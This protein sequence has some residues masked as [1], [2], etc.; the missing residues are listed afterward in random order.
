MAPEGEGRGGPE[1]SKDDFDG[2]DL[3]VGRPEGR[4]WADR[5]PPE[6]KERCPR[7]HPPNPMRTTM[8]SAKSSKGLSPYIRFLHIW[9]AGSLGTLRATH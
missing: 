8:P 3:L 4:R 7:L 9:G 6:Q 1:S 5:L 2:G